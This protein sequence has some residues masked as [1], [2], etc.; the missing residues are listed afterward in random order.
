MLEA[1]HLSQ[2]LFWVNSLKTKGRAWITILLCQLSTLVTHSP[3]V[4]LR[5]KPRDFFHREQ[6]WDFYLWLWKYSLW[7]KQGQS[8]PSAHQLG[9]EAGVAWCAVVLIEQDFRAR[10]GHRLWRCRAASQGW[11]FS[12]FLAA[13]FSNPI[14]GPVEK[15]SIAY[16]L[17]QHGLVH[18]LLA[19]C[20][21][22]SQINNRRI[23]E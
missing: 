4:R 10:Q 7:R 19:W 20:K 16:K 13:T 1:Q 22:G 15:T 21:R 3:A 8:S 9:S 23:Q 14:P 2:G 11:A 6:H 5:L 17:G 18:V 12:T